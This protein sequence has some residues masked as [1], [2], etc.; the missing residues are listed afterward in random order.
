M[1]HRYNQNLL[2]VPDLQVEPALKQLQQIWFCIFPYYISLLNLT[3]LHITSVCTYLQISNPN[4][5]FCNFLKAH[6]YH[7]AY[8]TVL[9]LQSPAVRKVHPAG[10]PAAS[11]ELVTVKPVTHPM[12]QELAPQPASGGYLTDMWM[13]SSLELRLKW[14]NLIRRKKPLTSFAV[15]LMIWRS[16]LWRAFGTE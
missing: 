6:W 11:P 16:L 15:P 3:G 9:D 10:I 1:D 14:P 12:S 5:L 2:L 4:D 7:L 13:G 8:F